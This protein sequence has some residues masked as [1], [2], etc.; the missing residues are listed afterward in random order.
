MGN[1]KNI[2]KIEFVIEDNKYLIDFNGEF[3]ITKD[4][5][6]IIIDISNLLLSDIFELVQKYPAPNDEI[7]IHNYYN[8]IDWIYTFVR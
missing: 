8:F 7:N 4:I 6:E 5:G 3:I 2:Q 1:L